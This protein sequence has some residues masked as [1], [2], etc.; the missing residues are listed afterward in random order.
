MRIMKSGI[1]SKY[2]QVANVKVHYLIAG[3]GETILFLHG[4]PTSSYLWRNII[5]ELSD[6]FQVIAIDLPGFGKSDKRSGDSYSFR[7]YSRILTGFLSNLGINKLTLGVHDLGGPLGLYWLINN[8]DRVNRLILLNTLVY[9]KFSFMVKLF[10]LSTVLPGIRHWLSSSRGIKWSM[11]FGVNQK[12]KLTDE[13]IENYQIPFQDKESRKSLLKSIHR[14]SIKGY[15]EIEANLSSFSN[16][17]QILFGE[18]D[19]IL[20]KVNETMQKVKKDLPQANV[21]SYPECGHFIQEEIPEELG[22]RIKEFME[23]S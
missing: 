4:W 21:I 1:N 12:E 2:T 14:L 10:Y 18:K 19:K 17:V 20:P 5:P 22:K 15:E 23:V 11:K 8:Q 9:P 3:K 16:P 13:I 6:H 7:Y